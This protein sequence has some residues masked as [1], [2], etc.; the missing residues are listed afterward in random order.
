MAAVLSSIAYLLVLAN[1]AFPVIRVS[2]PLANMILFGTAQL[3]LIPVT[4][5]GLRDLPTRGTKLITALLVFVGYP[6]SLAVV[7][8]IA[9]PIDPLS[10]PFA[11]LSTQR[12]R[13][14]AYPTVSGGVSFRQEC[15]L[16]RGIVAV[17]ELGGDHPAFQVQLELDGDTVQAFLPEDFTRGEATHRIRLAH[18]PCS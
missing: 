17:R 6:V 1:F 14:I 11:A 3:L 9:D 16:A 7:S 12:G 18:L 2:S 5:A 8:F 10:E 4:A 15:E 13:V